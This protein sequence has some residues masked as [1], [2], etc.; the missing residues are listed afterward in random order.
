MKKHDHIYSGFVIMTIGILLLLGNMGYISWSVLSGFSKIWPLILV[1]VGLN[2]FFNNHVLIKIVTFAGLVVAVIAAGLYYPTTHDWKFDF[3][4]NG[5]NHGNSA[6]QS[7][8]S[9]EYPLEKNIKSAELNLKLPA[10]A[11]NLIGQDE[12]LLRG[13]FPGTYAKESATTTDG[14]SRKVFNLDGGAFTLNTGSND[15]SNWQYQY[16][17]NSGIPWDI[18]IEAGATEA[19]LDF[20]DII[21]KNLE[22]NSGAGDIDIR[23]GKVER[24][25]IIVA[26]VKASDFRVVIPENMG[27]KAVIKGALHDI[28]IEGNDYVKE[29]NVYTSANYMTATEKVDLNLDV[30]VGDIQIELE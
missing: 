10:G 29:G 14:G 24:K 11:L 3:N 20:S 9:K 30:A 27:Y 15:S 7:S 6:E 4:F 8:I 13:E 5:P 28:S 23:I 2:M 26:D 22:L 25:A 19:D 18:R 1:A 16:E 17:L 12:G 21:L